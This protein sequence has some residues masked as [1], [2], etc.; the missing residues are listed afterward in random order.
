MIA[1]NRTRPTAVGEAGDSVLAD[2]AANLR[3][4][5]YEARA[6]AAGA[7]RTPVICIC[8]G[9]GGVGKTMLAANLAITLARRGR[10]PL[11]IDADLGTPNVDLVLGLNPARRFDPTRSAVTAPDLSSCIIRAHDGLRFIPGASA[12]TL[13]P[14]PSLQQCRELIRAAHA[15]TPAPGLV[16][17]DAGAGVG[18]GVLHFSAVASLVVV[19][20]TPDPPSIADAYAMLKLVHRFR[21]GPANTGCSTGIVINQ[22]RSDEEAAATFHRLSVCAQRFLDSTPLDLGW[23]P[24]DEAAGSSVRRRVPLVVASAESAAS[25]AIEGLARRLER[26]SGVSD[27]RESLM[28]FP[29]RL[30]R[31]VFFRGGRGVANAR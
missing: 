20:A 1:P 28:N 14:D 26:A 19:V 18:R 30:L 12:S 21:D 7:P 8:S 3:S 24:S 5:A 10:G 4:L 29:A 11:L 31:K 9:K 27:N 15:L 16:L 25:R 6:H 2:Q 13:V 17:I 22:A 23:V